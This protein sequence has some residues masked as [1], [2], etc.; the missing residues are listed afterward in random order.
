M[1]FTPI[2][3]V[4]MRYKTF[5]KVF[6]SHSKIKFDHSPDTTLSFSLR[7]YLLAFFLDFCA[8]L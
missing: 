1:D 7:L 6:E 2:D 8:L 3:P 5:W 4:I